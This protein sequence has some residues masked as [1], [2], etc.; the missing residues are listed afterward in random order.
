[1]ARKQALQLAARP[2]AAMRLTKELLK[3]DYAAQQKETIA[4]EM[5]NF[6][7]RLKSPEAAE[8]MRAFM[9]KR[10]PDFSAFS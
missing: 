5:A 3:R 2:A 4:Y 10:D 8:A 1:M 7:E 6:A 9:E